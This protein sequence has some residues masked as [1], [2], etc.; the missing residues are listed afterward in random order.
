[1][2]ACGALSGTRQFRVNA[3]ICVIVKP[4]QRWGGPIVYR[5]TGDGIRPTALPLRW[6]ADDEEPTAAA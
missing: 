5:C 2:V 6:T 4:H 1:M 3:W